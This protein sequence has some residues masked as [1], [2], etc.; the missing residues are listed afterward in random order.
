MREHN[1]ELYL[2]KLKKYYWEVGVLPTF[3]VMKE[4][5]GV[6]SRDLV[7]RFFSQMLER[8]F[9]EKESPKRYIP[10]NKLI[11]SPLYGS[12]VCGTADEIESNIVNYID[13]NKYIIGGNPEGIVL[14]ET[15]GDSMEDIGIFEGDIVS[16]D[17]NNKYPHSGDLVIATIDGD[18]NFTLK[19]YGQDKFG[20]PLLRYRN[21]RIYPGKIIEANQMN[22]VGV[23]KGLVRKF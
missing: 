6:K 19:E 20:N 14:V 7:S 5:I 21:E 8:G 9:I 2:G 4:L 12:V 23:V 15:K 3:D 16:V 22:V 1:F 10:T 13:L 11:A 17:L 18:G